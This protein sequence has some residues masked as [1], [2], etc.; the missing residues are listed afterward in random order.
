MRFLVMILCVAATCIATPLLIQRS[1]ADDNKASAADVMTQLKELQAKV[2]KLE[3]RIVELEKRPCLPPASTGIL[4][5]SYPPSTGTTVAPPLFEG[6]QE[7]LPY[8]RVRPTQPGWG[9]GVINGIPYY[10]VPLEAKR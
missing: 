1:A 2:V 10:I 7:P 5:P 3:A 6:Q 9:G 8:G 4:A